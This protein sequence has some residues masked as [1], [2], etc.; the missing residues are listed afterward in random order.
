M[1]KFADDTKLYREILNNEDCNILQND[2][3]TLVRW[4]CEWK[5]LF[6][7]D[8]CS[9]MHLGRKNNKNVY[10]MDTALEETTL[11]RDLGLLVDN[12]I[13]FSTQCTV[14]AKKVIEY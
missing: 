2:L 13:K 1:K 11:E 4:S 12:N 6:N 5:M 3:N 10:S 9:V 8:K 7:V 14:A